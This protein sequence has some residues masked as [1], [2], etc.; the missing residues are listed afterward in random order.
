MARTLDALSE[1]KEQKQRYEQ[2]RQYVEQEVRRLAKDLTSIEDHAEVLSYLYW[3]CE[4]IPASR[5]YEIFRVSF[6][7]GL[8]RPQQETLPCRYCR[9]SMSVLFAS[10]EAM[11]HSDGMGTC[12]LCQHQIDREKEAKQQASKDA[13]ERQRKAMRTVY[14]DTGLSDWDCFFFETLLLEFRQ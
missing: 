3:Q 4:D 13:W 8:I 5:L 12:A 6:H 11:K 9:Q 14:D 1:M 2:A 7:D 10:R